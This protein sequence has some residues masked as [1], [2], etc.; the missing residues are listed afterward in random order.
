MRHAFNNGDLQIRGVDMP[1]FLYK[2]YNY[3]PDDPEEGLFQGPFLVC[4]SAY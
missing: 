2:D 1:T 4:V 3:N